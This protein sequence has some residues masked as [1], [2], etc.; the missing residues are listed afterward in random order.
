MKYII[1]KVLP[2]GAMW[3]FAA[4]KGQFAMRP[5]VDGSVRNVFAFDSEAEAQAHLDKQMEI[6]PDLDQL[7]P[8]VIQPMELAS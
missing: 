3:A 7:G 1:V 5:I 2:S 6:A 4:H 8:F